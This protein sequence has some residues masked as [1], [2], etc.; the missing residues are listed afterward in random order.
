MILKSGT[1]VGIL[2]AWIL[3]F[4]DLADKKIR[5][6][7]RNFRVSSGGEQVFHHPERQGHLLRQVLRGQDRHEMHQVQD[8]PHQRRGHFQVNGPQ[9]V[10]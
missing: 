9:E 8:H 7:L 2:E 6:I 3:R 5:D 4:P 1:K 10:L